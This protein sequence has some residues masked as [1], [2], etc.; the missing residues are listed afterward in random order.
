[1]PSYE[2]PWN[3]EGAPY[4]GE[5]AEEYVGFVY[6]ITNKLTGRAYIGKKKLWAP[7]TSYVKHPKTGLK[8]KVRSKVDSDWRDYYGSSRELK[9]DIESLGK[10]NF[11]REILSLCITLGNMSYLELRNQIDNRVM[12]SDA[13]YNGFVGGRINKVHLKTQ[14]D[15]NISAPSQREVEKKDGISV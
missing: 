4:D 13:W 9:E 12:E 2:N 5:N 14:P 10:E 7:K 3:Y 8:K 1:M 11:K 15:L 6:K